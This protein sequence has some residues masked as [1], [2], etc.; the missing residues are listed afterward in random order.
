MTPTDLRTPVRRIAPLAAIG[1]LVLGLAGCGG[2]AVAPEEVEEQIST[3]LAEQYG[4]APDDV[5]CPEELPAEVDAQIT[6]L[7]TEGGDTLDVIVTVTDV[8]EENV[9]F[10]VEVADEVN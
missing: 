1:V 3:R 9:S 5:S 2:K 8:E 10:D 6:C 4:E 7:L